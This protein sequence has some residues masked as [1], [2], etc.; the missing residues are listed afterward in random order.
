MSKIDDLVA[1]VVATAR[2]HGPSS[3]IALAGVPGTGKSF[4]ATQVALAL[5]GHSLLIKT[6]Q[7][8][9]GFS[10]D[11]FMEGFRPIPGGFELQNGILMQINEQARRD[12]TNTYVL[13]IEEFTRANVTAVLGELLTYIEYRD[14]S[15]HVPSGRQLRLAPNLLFLTT[16]NPLDRSALELDDAIIRRL[17]I[18]TVDP[19]AEVLADLL[20]ANTPEETAFKASL[21]KNFEKLCDDCRS[22]DGSLLPFGH[23][24][25]RGLKGPVGLRSLWDEQIRFLVRRPGLPPHPLADAIEELVLNVERELALYRTTAVPASPV[26]SAGTQVAPLPAIDAGPTQSE[27]GGVQEKSGI[28]SSVPAQ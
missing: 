12:P 5:T 13:L 8:H 4:V 22:E 26:E 7:F 27:P 28:A 16:Y 24:V 1:K 2:L 14:R 15:F 20:T 25:F 10:Y 3:L 6:I 17:R 18:I 23:A 9:P 19:S 21:V 11:D